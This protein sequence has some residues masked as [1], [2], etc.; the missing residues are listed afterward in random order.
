M[1]EYQKAMD[2]TLI[3]LQNTYCFLDD[4]IIVSTGSGSDHLAYVTKSLKK[5]DEDAAVLT[6]PP[7]SSLKPLRS[8]RG[9]VKCDASRSGLG[10]ALEQKTPDG[11]KPISFASQFL[12]STEK[13]YSVNEL[14]L[15]GIV[16]SIDYF[17]YY[18]YL[19]NFIVII[20]H[21]EFLSILKEPR[22]NESQNSR[23]S[24]WIYRL[25]P[26]NFTIEHMPGAKMGL[27]DY[28]SRNPF[29]KAKK[30]SHLTGIS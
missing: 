18:F 11:W 26:Y 4:I 8:F 17:R 9:S 19:K 14:E 16:W 27:V 21:R 20:D 25:L 7:P 6:I 22:S 23:L 5:L 15:L 2:Y 13:R 28:I 24:R 29:A 10:A 12:K 1:A 3:G 30:F